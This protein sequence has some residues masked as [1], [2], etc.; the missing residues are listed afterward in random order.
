MFSIFFVVRD[1][2]LKFRFSRKKR[3]LTSPLFFSPPLR[4]IPCPQLSTPPPCPAP[5]YPPPLSTFQ[6]S[7]P[8]PAPA[9]YYS[10]PCAPPCGVRPTAEHFG[11]SRISFY[12][13]AW[14]CGFPKGSSLY[15]PMGN[16]KR[17]K[18]GGYCIPWI[19]A[20]NNRLT[21]DFFSRR[22]LDIFLPLKLA[23]LPVPMFR[24]RWSSYHLP[25][26]LTPLGRV[27]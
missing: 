8:P 22:E 27:G 20:Q 13:C 25:P 1:I 16:P 26:L 12:L 15:P 2:F 23:S 6:L 11:S 19:F 5:Y 3:G 4:K 10:P 17:R 9:P 21:K 18:L 7:T 24:C 14:V